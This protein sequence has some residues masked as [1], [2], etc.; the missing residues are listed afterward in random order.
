MGQGIHNGPIKICERQPL[1]IFTWQSILEYFDP[2]RKHKLLY[3]YSHFQ[4][5][6]ASSCSRRVD[7]VFFIQG[8]Y[9]IEVTIGRWWQVTGD[10]DVQATIQFHSLEPD[11]KQVTLVRYQAQYL[12]HRT[13][14]IISCCLVQESS[15]SFASNMVFG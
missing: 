14:N 11:N 10:T 3:R 2:N 7:N 12:F 5:Y 4:F 6:R 13:I 15:P 9:T 8:G 1:K